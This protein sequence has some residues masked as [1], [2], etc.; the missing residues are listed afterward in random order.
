MKRKEKNDNPAVVIGTILRVRPFNTKNSPKRA[1]SFLDFRKWIF[2]L[3]TFFSW[4]ITFFV[5]LIQF[6][7][8]LFL[9]L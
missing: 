9:F 4:Q 2:L 7:L 3:K 1:G 8:Q 6:T 5:I